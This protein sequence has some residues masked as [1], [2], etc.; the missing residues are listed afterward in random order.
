MRPARTELL[1]RL[2]LP[3]HTML[4]WTRKVTVIGGKA[5]PDDWIIL[6]QGQKVGR[7]HLGPMVHSAQLWYWSTQLY[8]SDSGRAECLEEA[9]TA[10]RAAIR[11][12]WEDDVAPPLP[13]GGPPRSAD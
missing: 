9:L 13:T 7:A 4:M 10:I 2:M 3:G 12:H 1:D 11:T 8:P 5:W 6:R